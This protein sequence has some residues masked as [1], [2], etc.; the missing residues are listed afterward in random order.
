MQ[1]YVFEGTDTFPTIILDKDKG[2]F[3]LKGRSTPENGKEFFEPALEW[4]S[5]YT[6]SPNPETEFRFEL[7]FFNISSSKI[8]LFILYKLLDIQNAGNKV[9]VTWNYNDAY[10]LGAGRDYA[11]MVKVPFEFKKT[12]RKEK[13]EKDIAA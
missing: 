1:A 11:Y 6:K 13:L 8:I 2:T 5:A 10:L 7:E 12:A 9:K 3:L 4:L